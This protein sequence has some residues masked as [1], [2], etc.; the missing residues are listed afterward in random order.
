MKK[1]LSLVLALVMTMSLVT[2][3]AGAT[4]YK[5]TVVK[6]IYEKTVTLEGLSEESVPET[7]D[8]KIGEKMYPLTLSKVDY[9]TNDESTTETSSVEYKSCYSKPD[10]PDTAKISCVADG[11]ETEI[12]GKLK[13][14]EPK[15]KEYW[16]KY[17]ESGRVT[18]PAGAT[19]YK[20]NG[21]EI[22]YDESTPKYKGYEKD[23]LKFLNLSDATNKVNDATW[24]GDGKVKDDGT[25]VR[26]I[27]Y[28][29]ERK[30]TD[31][32]AI[33]TAEV[34][35]VTYTANAVYRGT[36]KDLGFDESFANVSQ[37]NITAIAHYTLKQVAEAGSFVGS[38]ARNKLLLP[39]IC[40]ILA[41]AAII[42]GILGFKKQGVEV[43]YS[44]LGENNIDEE[45]F[46]SNLYDDDHENVPVDSEPPEQDAESFATSENPYS[47]WR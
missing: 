6:N 32:T 29:C 33:Y 12:E 8:F 38:F 28:Q 30:V 34:K 47:Q 4:E 41:A 5:D 2:V 9:T 16:E 18:M 24:D 40:F 13:S 17:E 31:W 46:Q 42:S 15:G 7:Q 19:S 26:S 25:L 43:D 27:T 1:F 20:Y 14:V 45:Q 37:K 36:V 35:N 21:K 39:L 23:L 11:E 44:D 22:P 10:V 3:S